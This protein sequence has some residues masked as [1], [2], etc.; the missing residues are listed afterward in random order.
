MPA[1]QAVGDGAARNQRQKG[2]TR[3]AVPGQQP[4]R[5]VRR[6][7]AALHRRIQHA[8]ER[9]AVAAHAA[10]DQ[11]RPVLRDIHAGTLRHGHLDM[12]PRRRRRVL[13]DIVGAAFDQLGTGDDGA[14]LADADRSGAVARH[15]HH[16]MHDAGRGQ[17]R[18]HLAPHRRIEIG[19]NDGGDPFRSAIGTERVRIVRRKTALLETEHDEATAVVGQRGDVAGQFGAVFRVVEVAPALVLG[20]QGTAGRLHQVLRVARRGGGEHQLFRSGAGFGGAGEIQ[21]HH[22]NDVIGNRRYV[23][24]Q[25]REGFEKHGAVRSAGAAASVANFVGRWHGNYEFRHVCFSVQRRDKG[26]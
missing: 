20:F 11:R 21:R 4:L 26:V 25:G 15:T 13:T 6:G 10:S 12:P 19:A 23:G 17:N 22:R 9:L 24:R 5:E 2:G 3:G 16:R 8:Q 7:G 14:V 18:H 1:R